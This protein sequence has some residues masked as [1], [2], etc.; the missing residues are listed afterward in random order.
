MC[1][2]ADAI[3][4]TTAD[5]VDIGGG[6]IAE[7]ALFEA[8]A[9]AIR[10]SQ[11]LFSTKTQWISEP[12]RFLSGPVVTLTV[13]VIGRKRRQDM[14]GGWVYTLDESVYGSFSNIPFDGQRPTYRLMVSDEELKNRPVS[15]AM[16]FGHT[17]DSAD[18][19]AENIALP[20]LRVGDVLE[21]ADMGAYTSVS[22]SHFNGFPMPSRSYVEFSGPRT[23]D[24]IFEEFVAICKK[25]DL[26]AMQNYHDYYVWTSGPNYLTFMSNV[27]SILK[28]HCVR[29][30]VLNWFLKQNHSI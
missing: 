16:L 20:E 5:I 27:Y 6:F 1:A 14:S 12:G 28:Q 26:V 7:P 13:S 2:E 8:A 19:L 23:P 29:D 17:C 3:A 10:K 25:G 11:A 24:Q 30:S 22:A 21:V 4:K 18:C 9:A 15:S